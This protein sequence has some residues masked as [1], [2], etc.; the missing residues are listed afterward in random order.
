M[1]DEYEVN[2]TGETAE[3]ITENIE[4]NIQDTDTDEMIENAREILAEEIR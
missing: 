1:M 2:S 4:E 3:N